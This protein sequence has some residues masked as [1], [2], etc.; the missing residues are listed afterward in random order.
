MM[1]LVSRAEAVI[2]K[3]NVSSEENPNVNINFFRKNKTE[4][5]SDKEESINEEEE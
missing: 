4:D 1:D 2:A 5:M 3:M